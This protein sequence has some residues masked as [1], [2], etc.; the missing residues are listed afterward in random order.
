[1]DYRLVKVRRLTACEN[2][3][4][5]HIYIDVLDK[6]GNGL[7][8]VPVWVSWGGE[9]VELMTGSKPERG[10]GAVEFPMYKGTHS[11]EIKGARSEIATG[12]TPDIPVDEAC[13]DV[14]TANSLYHYS[15][16]VVFQRTY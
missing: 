4:G 8:G 16:E 6:E 9:G 1:M 11:V 10:P 2:M 13:G 3:G 14:A 15:Y 5:H 7:P 12:I